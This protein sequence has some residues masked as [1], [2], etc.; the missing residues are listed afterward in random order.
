MR[1]TI[2]ALLALWLVIGGIAAGPRGYF[3]D[4]RAASCRTGA[5]TGLTFLAGPLNYA[6]VNPT[7]SCQ[8][9]HP[10]A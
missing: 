8:T 9:P 4:D 3:G 7:I 6:G 5:N 2:G 10:S 1:L